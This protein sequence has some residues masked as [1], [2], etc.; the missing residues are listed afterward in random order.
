MPATRA[1]SSTST[2][3]KSPR[4]ASRKR[5]ITAA[6]AE[7][8]AA[9]K[10]GVELDGVRVRIAT[11][12]DISGGGLGGSD[13]DRD[14]LSSGIAFIGRRASDERLAEAQLNQQLLQPY[15]NSST[16]SSAFGNQLGVDFAGAGYPLARSLS[17]AESTS[18]SSDSSPAAG[19][20][21]LPRLSVDANAAHTY[22]QQHTPVQHSAAMMP[23]HSLPQGPGSTSVNP[24]YTTPYG[25]VQ[26][27]TADDQRLFAPSSPITMQGGGG[28]EDDDD[29][30]DSDGEGNKR[31]GKSTS[32][33]AKGKINV[34]GDQDSKTGRRKINISFIEDDARRHITFSKRKAGIMKKV[35]SSFGNSLV[36]CS[37]TMALRTGV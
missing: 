9:T 23:A 33:G 11:G 21:A 26:L 22:S 25:T 30:D 29:D 6:A 37:L 12:D 28:D 3:S 14:S 36:I 31:K 27:A 16:L 10:G 35:S 7:G 1:P 34:K 18:A 20:N 24:I 13:R 2:R 19:I 32:P 8:V 5:S 17:P 4:L 15:Y